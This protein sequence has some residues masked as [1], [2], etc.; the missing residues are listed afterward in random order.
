MTRFTFYI[1][2]SADD[3]TSAHGQDDIRTIM[4]QVALYAEGEISLKRVWG[5][6]E[7]VAEATIQLD[8]ELTYDTSAWELADRIAILLEQSCVMVV[9]G[10]QSRDRVLA[11]NC[12]QVTVDSGNRTT[13]SL[14][15]PGIQFRSIMTG[16]Y[17]AVNVWPEHGSRPIDW[18]PED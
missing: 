13:T 17:V 10:R 4:R 15:K 7:D 2:S 5:V 12:D 6:W 8:I 14:R 11:Y 1:G 16:P 9:R 3:S 18:T